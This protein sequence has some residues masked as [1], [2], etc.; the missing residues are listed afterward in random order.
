M[1]FRTVLRATPS[2]QAM[3]GGLSPCRWSSR[4]MKRSPS[5]TT[6][7]PPPAVG[8]VSATT[9]PAPAGTSPGKRPCATKWGK[10]AA[11][12]RG[13]FNVRRHVLAAAVHAHGGPLQHQPGDRLAVLLR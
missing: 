10:F 11:H 3:A 8:A 4:I 13:A 9:R 7:P 5:R 1:Y 12:F 2:C 6:D